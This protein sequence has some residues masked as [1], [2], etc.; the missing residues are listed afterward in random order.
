MWVGC[1]VL[2]AVT[3]AGC[4]RAS[5]GNSTAAGGQVAVV[6]L[7][8]PASAEAEP[9]AV[10]V[11]A[12]S[13]QVQYRLAGLETRAEDLTAEIERVGGDQIRRWRVDAVPPDGAPGQHAVV[14]P[15]YEARPGEYV[16]TVWAGDADIVQRYRFRVATP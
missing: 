7:A 14:V 9:A 1:L 10:S 5:P 8:P 11:P 6:H 12:G 3:T 4:R 16:L 13:V 15:I 2:V